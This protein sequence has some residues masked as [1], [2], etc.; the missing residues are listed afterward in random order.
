MRTC[1]LA[2][3]LAL[4]DCVHGLHR[5]IHSGLKGEPHHNASA[6]RSISKHTE[7]VGLAQFT[8][9]TT[10]ANVLVSVTNSFWFV[11]NVASFVIG[12]SLLIIGV[13]GLW[14]YERQ[15]ARVDYL[16]TAGLDS[17]K[18]PTGAKASPENFGCLVY[19][20]GMKAE[21]VNECLDP[22]F[23]CG[24]LAGALRIRTS[25][26]AFQSIQKSKLGA[27]QGVLYESTWSEVELPSAHFKDP[28]KIYSLPQDPSLGT[29]VTTAE[30]VQL[31]EQFFLPGGLVDQ[32]VDFRPASEFLGPQVLTRQGLRFLRHGD[33][34]YYCRPGASNWTSSQLAQNPV[35]GDM[36]VRFD[37]IPAG[38]VTVMA[39]QAP[40]NGKASFCPFRLLSSGFGWNLLSAEQQMLVQEGRKS[41]EVLAR[42]ARCLPSSAFCCFCNLLSGTCVGVHT[43]EIYMC[44]EGT[45][46]RERCFQKVQSTSFS[47]VQSVGAFTV[48]L[49]ALAAIFSGLLLAFSKVLDHPPLVNLVMAK[50]MGSFRRPF[51]CLIGSLGLGALL[52][53]LACPFHRPITSCCWILLAVIIVAVPC[54]TLSNW[55]DVDTP[56]NRLVLMSLMEVNHFGPMR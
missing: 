28:S 43:P 36:R 18:F 22:R 55:G 8:G 48:R 13:P 5:Q 35:G 38:P 27:P 19:L 53:G 40:D 21:A 44:L 26:E 51:T 41:R 50:T 23:I 25:V 52:V 29:T 6:G 9:N 10:A 47:Y 56:S 33:G 15:R 7:D 49:V 20:A 24:A 3:L 45:V 34:V 11:Q 17:C 39:L 31:G 46:S 37:Y 54:L 16:I 12:L 32:C 42:E 1:K 30:R 2:V 14:F 4:L